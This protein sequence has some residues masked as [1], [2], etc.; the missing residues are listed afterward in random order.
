MRVLDACAAPGGKSSHLLEL[1]DLELTAL[2]VDSARAQDLRRTLGRLQLAGTAHIR[3]ADCTDT[4]RWWDGQP[5]DRI[6][7]FRVTRFSGWDAGD[8][9][10]S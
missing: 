1:A 2:D 10:G 9:Y 3:E 6:L 8:F 4:A 7:V 5:F